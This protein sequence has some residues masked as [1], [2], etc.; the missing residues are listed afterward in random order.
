MGSS[1]GITSSRLK[2]VLD[3]KSALSR[4]LIINNTGIYLLRFRREFIAALRQAGHEVSVLAPRDHAWDR[5]SELGVPVTEWSLRQHGM[6]PLSELRAMFHAWREIRRVKP[7]VVLNFTIKPSIYG[8]LAAHFAGVRR[9]HSVFTGLG[10]FFTHEDNVDSL[11]TRTIRWMLRRALAH[12]SSVFFQNDDDRDLFLKLGLVTRERTRKM[13]GSGINL[14]AF[15][16]AGA[17]VEPGSFVLVGRMLPE[18]GVREFVEAAR[19]L[20]PK[21]PNAR[22]MLLGGIDGSKSAIPRTEIEGWSTQPRVEYLGEVDDVRSVVERAEV[23]VLPSY[24]E[25]LPRSVL[26]AMALGKAIVT[27]DVSGCRDTVIEGRNGTLVPSRD[28][29]ALSAA[30]ERFLLDAT[31]AQRY[32]RESRILA[33]ER[34]DVRAVNATFLRDTGL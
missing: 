8:S 1:R 33:E 5:L 12:N 16:P 19:I 25:G 15:A 13:N 24:R 31:L 9:I 4:V 26:E 10:Y 34:F 11:V 14:E 22:F 28:P 32:G 2:D 21:Y 27:T 30:M 23:M 17:A 18:K 29:K 3:W 6:S 20:R 7:D